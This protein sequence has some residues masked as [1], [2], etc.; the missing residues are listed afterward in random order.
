M[1]SVRNGRI[2]SVIVL[3]IGI[4]GLLTVSLVY[5][6]SGGETGE[7]IPFQYGIMLDAGSTKTQVTVYKWEGQKDNGTGIVSQVDTCKAKGGLDKEKEIFSAGENILPCIDKVSS[8]I[9]EEQH[10]TTPLYLAATAGMRL[11]RLGEPHLADGII[12][13]VKYTLMI[14][15]NFS[16]RD[17]T[18]IRGRDEGMFAWV[19]GNFL[20]DTLHSEESDSFNTYG[21]LD[22]GGA[23]T[24]LAFEIPPRE[25]E[26]IDNDTTVNMKLYGRDHLVFAQSY[27]CFGINEAM[28]RYRAVL[29][30]DSSD[31]NVVDPCGFKDDIVERDAKYLYD[32]QCTRSLYS[33]NNK[34]R[35]YKFKGTG[36]NKKC[37]AAVGRLI[38]YDECSKMFYPCFKTPKE[39]LANV[40]YMAVS[41]FYYVANALNVTNS[42]LE[43]FRMAFQRYCEYSKS[44]AENAL[45]PDVASYARDYCLE[46]HYVHYVLT[47]EYG[48][49]EATWQNIMFAVQVNN[50]DLGWSLG[51]MINATNAIPKTKPN[52][53]RRPPMITK[54][55]FIVLLVIFALVAIAS[56]LALLF[57]PRRH[58]SSIT[59]LP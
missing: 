34:D 22:M 30:K 47:E 5:K 43:D 1:S 45:N 48:F 16:I 29:A 15:S 44:E 36:D 39:K 49:N 20:L 52:I 24:Q 7:E 42:T 59:V 14:N 3:V 56:I 12:L 6:L 55:T 35:I 54:S 4:C 10:K 40:K 11:L 50:T 19:T 17:V 33:E 2:L 18:I 41:T 58:Q 28:R 51:Y 8:S 57:V 37:T 13:G 27:L 32:H 25:N 46:A 53:S 26:A 9:P 31:D 38:N 23:S 21:S